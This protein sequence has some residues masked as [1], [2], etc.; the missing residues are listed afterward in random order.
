MTNNNDR[1]LVSVA[2][3]AYKAVYLQEALDSLLRQTYRPLEL[4]ICDDS[5]TDEVET[6]VNAFRAVADF[7]VLYQRNET[8]LWEVRSTTRCV[9]LASGSYIKFLH[10]DDRLHPECIESLLAVMEADPSVAL[11]SSRR[12]LIDEE[13]NPL[14]DILATVFPFREDVLIDGPGLSSFLADYTVNFIGEPSTVMCRR[15]DLLEFGEQMAVL[16][17]VRITWVADLAL[18]VK[19][20]QRGHLGMLAKPLTDFRVSREQFSQLGRDTPGIGEKAHADF[21][22]A[23]RDLGWYRNEGNRFVDVA[24][25]TRL[26]AR[27]FKPMDILG[28]IYKAA[29]QSGVSLKDWLAARQLTPVQQR[30]V[31]Q[32]LAEHDGGPRIAVMVLDQQGDGAAVERT[33]VSLTQNDLHGSLE[34]RLLSITA[35]TPATDSIEVISLEQGRQVA[36]INAALRK[37]EA[38]WVLLV[39]AGAEFTPNGLRIVALE[40]IGASGC[41]VVYADEILLGADGERGMALRPDF[42]LDLLLSFPAGMARHWLFRRDLLLEQGGFEAEFEQAF[43]LAYVLRL[44]EQYGLGGL[45]HISEP[46]LTANLGLLQDNPEERAVIERHLRS[47][48]YEQ[49]QAISSAPGCY[50]L[51]YGHAQQAQVSILIVVKDQLA[52]VQRCLESLLE[53]TAYPHYEVLLLAQGPQQ[54]DTDAWLAAVEAVGEGRIRVLRFEDVGN[55]TICNQAVAEARGDMLLWLSAGAGLFD[56]LWLQQ[57]LNHAMRPEVGAVGGLLMSADGRVRH[58]G[59]LLGLQGP[60]GRAFE[61]LSFDAGGYMQ[62]LQVEQNYSALSGECLMLRRELFIELGGFDEDRQLARWADVDLCLKARQAGYLNVWTPRAKVLMDAQALPAPSPAQE[63]AMYAKW[64][65]ILARDPAYNPGFSLQAEQGFKLA[66]PQLSWRPLQAWR[67]LPT[68]LAHPADLFGCGN[69]RVIQPFMAMKDAGLVDG[70][71]SS[72]LM[73][74]ADLERFEPD[75]I[76]LQRQIGEARL[77]AMRRMRAFSA[78]FKVYELDDYLPNLPLKNVHRQHMPKDIL[79]SLRRGL[80]FVDRFVVSTQ[81][82]AEAFAGLHPDIR[83]VENRLPATWWKGLQAKRQ[84]GPRPRVGW[85]GGSSHTGDLELIADVVQE[86]ANEVDWV[87]FGMCP[88]SIRPFVKEVHAGVDI[89]LYPQALAA[90]NL[91]LALAPVE[92]NLFNECKSNLRLLEYGACG[93]PVIC[94]D[95]RCYQD[96][97]PVTRVKNRFRD[98][99]EAIRMHIAD[100]DACAKAGDQLRDTVLRDWMLDGKNLKNWRAAWLP[101]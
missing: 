35:A 80:A 53:N 5:R 12:R 85:A 13:G 37:V 27:V 42:N 67:P 64:L 56:P 44:I 76:V 10:D 6:L 62:R 52:R 75:T 2:M 18:Y 79:K 29:G 57:L 61:G 26:K 55:E 24:P 38:D 21:R 28:A 25:I 60:A 8:R 98:W 17:G 65:P 97:L 96:G 20:L 7:P 101:D 54:A 36:A 78:A 82:L 48:G 94:S 69:Y 58:A 68:V 72:G 41:Q 22:Q 49:P 47:R 11:V 43:E 63:D 86:L 3:P 14:P 9:T 99:V 39:E 31:E 4:V 33:L 32:R 66:D 59:L 87:F 74:V 92:Q 90:L 40:L 46:L 88:E 73:H 100:L 71:L 93:F 16:N 77:E 30:L 70:V 1:P 84:S 91:D 15:S 19:L 95:V 50:Q 51:D 45:G 23:I 34:V 83:V 81:P 89:G